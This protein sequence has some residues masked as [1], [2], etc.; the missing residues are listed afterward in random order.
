MNRHYKFL[1]VS[2]L[3]AFAFLLIDGAPADAKGMGGVIKALG[4][5]IYNEKTLRPEELK[6]C[7][8]MEK[9]IK[10][11]ADELAKARGKLDEEKAKIEMEN[12]RIQ[13]KKKKLDRKNAADV[14]DFN[15][16]VAD[17]NKRIDKHGAAAKKY[18]ESA[19][20]Q[21]EMAKRYNTEC[22][23]K[24]YYDSDMKEAQKSLEKE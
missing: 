2:C 20:G 23:S 13:E 22:S 14:R 6:N 11:Q 17:L 19:Q 4:N 9:K 24:S 15:K 3:L 21:R 12:K 1:M 7:L 10:L 5:K 8:V 16:A 18:N